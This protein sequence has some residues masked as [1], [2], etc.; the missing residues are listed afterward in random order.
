M[1]ERRRHP[2]P[3]KLGGVLQEDAFRAILGYERRRAERSHRPFV[4][5]LIESRAARSNGT[6]RLERLTPVI[7]GA[8]RETDVIGWYE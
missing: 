2:G 1:E 5:M 3:I 6:A 4:L 7:S 8:I